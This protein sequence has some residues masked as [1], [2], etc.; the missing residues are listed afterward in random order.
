MHYLCITVPSTAPFVGFLTCT[1]CILIYHKTQ[2][3]ADGNTRLTLLF[4][5]KSYAYPVIL[6]HESTSH[7]GVRARRVS[8]MRKLALSIS[9]ISWTVQVN[10][11]VTA[12]RKL[13]ES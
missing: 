12:N 7:N 1:P 11:S 10:L 13:V 4:K 8:G 5:Y 9:D 3:L 6:D 2:K